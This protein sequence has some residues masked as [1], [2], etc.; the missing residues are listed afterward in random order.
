MM[1]KW[2]GAAP[3]PSQERRSACVIGLV[4][5]AVTMGQNAEC[6]LTRAVGPSRC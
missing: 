4:T 6:L 5:E 2:D 1:S 3:A